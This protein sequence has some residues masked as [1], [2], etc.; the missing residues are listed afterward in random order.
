MKLFLKSEK[1]I[2]AVAFVF[3]LFII[4]FNV[5][6]LAFDSTTKNAYTADDIK[7]LEVQLVN[8]NEADIET[9]CELPGIGEK[10]AEKIVEYREE[11]GGFDS[12]EEIKEVKGIGQ[13]DY[14]KMR[15][16]MTI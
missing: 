13:H 14:I 3:I 4:L 2:V 6:D 1:G 12:V 5:Y 16:L 15:P 10:T 11:N 9:L 7:A 8:I